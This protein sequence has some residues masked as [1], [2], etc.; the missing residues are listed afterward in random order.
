MWYRQNKRS[1]PCDCPCPKNRNRTV[2]TGE[3]RCWCPCRS[4]PSLHTKAALSLRGK[5]SVIGCRH[6]NR[7]KERRRLNL[8]GFNLLRQ[9]FFIFW[10]ASK[11]QNRAAICTVVH[12]VIWDGVNSGGWLF[13]WPPPALQQDADFHGPKGC[14]NPDNRCP[15][16]HS[17]TRW[18]AP[19]V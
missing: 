8:D 3:T 14:I 17:G 7:K 6:C 13:P 2:G 15:C 16:S 18:R 1:N 10:I 11:K 19:E 4:G 5:S 12:K 9:L